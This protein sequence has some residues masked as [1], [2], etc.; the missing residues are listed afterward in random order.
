VEKKAPL[1]FPPTAPA[2]RPMEEEDLKEER[3]RVSSAKR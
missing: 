2:K 1:P 3:K